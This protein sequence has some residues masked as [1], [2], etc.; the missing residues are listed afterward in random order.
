M[1]GKF[2]AMTPWAF[3]ALGEAFQPSLPPEGAPRCTVN[4]NVTA[5]VNDGGVLEVD[6]RYGLSKERMAC[7]MGQG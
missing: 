1:T 4:L 3:S 2:T 6:A 7:G 5:P